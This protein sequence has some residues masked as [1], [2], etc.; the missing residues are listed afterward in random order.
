MIDR[1]IMDLMRPGLKVG[2]AVFL[3]DFFEADCYK[4]TKKS[5]I[6]LPIY[7][8][9]LTVEKK[10]ILAVTSDTIVEI[11][12]SSETSGII[13]NAFELKYVNKVS[14]VHSKSVSLYFLNESQEA[15]KYYMND[16]AICI[17]CIQSNLQKL[18]IYS[19]PSMC[20]NEPLI[21]HLN[22]LIS[23]IHWLDLEFSHS[24]SIGLIDELMNT[25]RDAMEIACTISEEFLC[26]AALQDIR[27]FV[28]TFLQKASVAQLLDGDDDKC[29]AHLSSDCDKTIASNAERRNKNGSDNCGSSDHSLEEAADRVADLDLGHFDHTAHEDAS[30]GHASLVSPTAS[31]SP[32][33][34]ESGSHR[35]ELDTL[36]CDRAPSS[37]D[38][39]FREICQEYMDMVHSFIPISNHASGIGANSECNVLVEEDGSSYEVADD[40][41]NF[42]VSVHD[43]PILTCL[44]DD[45]S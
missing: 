44:I 14:F 6:H 35:Q 32:Y 13:Q 43:N 29:S 28:Q 16:A 30:V 21:S 9:L 12:P 11:Y 3:S 45:S 25:F 19:I 33:R 37:L 39:L 36:L 22:D 17:K 7:P 38:D 18:G 41:I 4:C 1:N 20:R 2:G 23:H 8:Y 34:T 5:D 15:V 40:P 27:Y 31:L 42:P 10:R 26:S 24:P